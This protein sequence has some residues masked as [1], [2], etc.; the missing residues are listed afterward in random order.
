M[1]IQIS[2]DFMRGALQHSRPLTIVLLKKGPAFDRSS[3]VIWEHGRRNFLLR[4]QGDLAI[5]CP[6]TDDSDYTGV[7]VF[8]CDVEETRSIMDGD[9]GVQAG[10][11]VYEVHT[12]RSFP[13][14]AL[15][16]EAVVPR[17][18]AA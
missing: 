3:P 4:A 11:F 17:V 14:D 6:V 10:I 1:T 5:V 7:G 12:A 13:G 16:G 2:D 9:P 8:D 18:P 15:P